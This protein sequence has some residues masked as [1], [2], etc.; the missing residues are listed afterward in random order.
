MERYIC[1]HGHFYQPPREN[2]WLEA[3]ELQDSA[4][5]YHDWNERIDAECYAPNSASRILDEKGRI[6]DIVNNYARISYNFGPTLLAWLQDQAP[7]TY[8]LVIDADRLSAE[9][10]SGHGSALAQPYNHVIMPLANRRDKLT[11][12]RWG[13]RDFERR[14]GRFPE[15]M[16]L[17]ETAVDLE[18]LQIL[19]E[20]GI[21]FTVLSPYQA[22]RVR[23]KRRSWRDITG[24]RIDPT[25]AYWLRLPSRGKVTLFFYDGLISRAVAFERLLD[26]GENLAEKLAG[27][28]SGERPWGQLAHIA[29]DGETYGHHHQRGEMA[30]SYALKYIEENGLARLTNYG[31]YLEGHPPS[32]EVQ[33]YEN[34][35]WSCAHGVERWRS[36]CGCNTGGRPGWTQEWRGPLRETFDWLRDCVAPYYETK[37]REYLK[38]PWAARDDYID[39][40]LDRSPES[41]ER[42]FAKHAL[43]PLSGAGEIAALKLLELQRHAMLM[44]TSCGW[45]FDELSGIETVQVIQYAGRVLQLAKELGGPDLESPFLERLERARSNIPEH[46]NGRVIFEKFV[47]PA[48]VDLHK[49]GAHYAIASIFDNGPQQGRIYSYSVECKDSRLLKAGRAQFSI[50]K[51]KITSEVTRE[52]A[53]VT[54]G[55]AHLGDHTV[56]GGVRAYHGE[57]QYLEALERMAAV[58][59]QGDFPELIRAVDREFGPGTYSL[60]LLFRDE[61]RKILRQI[62]AASLAEAESAYRHI[63]ESHGGLARLLASIGMPAPKSL[64]AAAEVTLNNDLR[65]AFEQE[66]LDLGRIDALVEEAK[67]AK[68]PFDSATLE[69]SLRRTLERMAEQFAAHPGDT[70]MLEKLDAAAGMIHS[71]PFGVVLW[72]VQNLYYNMMLTVLPE[73]GAKAASG[74]LAAGKWVRQFRSL[75]ERLGVRVE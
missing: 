51:L 24:G 29:T 36:N 56:A 15:G 63:Y 11:Q 44:Y 8:Q 10:F 48:M 37:G 32:H 4:Y 41:R 42:F 54:F 66:E 17:P 23:Q 57:T 26:R 38:D 45:F 40:I 53:L 33:V 2:P 65:R 39:V 20:H 59:R 19:A 27:A 35:S 30:L 47:R 13:I 7:E 21:R 70:A 73:F 55:V 3:I 43:H 6:A 5:P 60:K 50:G 58:F 74:N 1:I 49:V 75:G 72:K 69:F 28:F 52:S 67:I 25:M 16:W 18:T 34:S 46:Q 12:V 62:L 64:E 68:V 31:E 71:L 22:R 9:R 14:F 61:Q